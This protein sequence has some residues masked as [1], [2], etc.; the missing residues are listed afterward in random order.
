MDRCQRIGPVPRLSGL[1]ELS[2]SLVQDY[3]SNEHKS[4]RQSFKRCE[5]TNKPTEQKI[6]LCH[7]MM[8]NDQKPIF[9]N[10]NNNFN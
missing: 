3:H 9:F 7:D 5:S 6:L 4:L 10:Y 1:L 8:V 2:G